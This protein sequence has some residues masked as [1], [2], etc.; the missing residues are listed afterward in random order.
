MLKVEGWFNIENA[1]SEYAICN[2]LLYS[3]QDWKFEKS[4]QYKSSILGESVPVYYQLGIQK[5]MNFANFFRICTKW[6]LSERNH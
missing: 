2:N 4:A 6:H 1:L 3:N 5:E